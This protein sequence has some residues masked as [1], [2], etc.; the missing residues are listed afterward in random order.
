AESFWTLACDEAEAFRQMATFNRAS[1]PISGLAF[2]DDSL[3]VR[4]SG[5]QVAV[6]QARS[7][8]RGYARG[9]ERFWVDLKEQRMAFFQQPENLWR[10][11]LPFRQAQQAQLDGNR[12]WDWGGGL[13]WLKSDVPSQEVIEFAKQADGSATLF[14]GDPGSAEWETSAANLA[15]R[16][17]LRAVFDP[18]DV[19]VRR[20]HW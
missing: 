10:I 4:F 12:I 14:R 15:I 9:N 6:E 20:G 13:C 2:N 16:K 8:V 7:A 19:F 3:H 1:L 11:T 5:S 18:S 17:R